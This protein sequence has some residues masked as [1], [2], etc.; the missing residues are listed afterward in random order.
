MEG[1]PV[2]PL[3]VDEG[4]EELDAAAVDDGAALVVGAIQV[5]VVLGVDGAT[6]VVVGCAAEGAELVSS[7]HDQWPHHEEPPHCWLEST[8]ETEVGSEPAVTVT[9]SVT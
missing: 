7:D 1:T 5:E 8:E 4:A 9:M 3:S 6:D 2:D